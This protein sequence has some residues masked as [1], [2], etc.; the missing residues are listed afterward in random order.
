MHRLTLVAAGRV[1]RQEAPDP[2][3]TG[4]EAAL[5][6]PIAASV[7]DFDRALISGVL[8]VLPLPIALGHEIVA[9]VVEIGEAVGEVKVGER[10][11]LPLQ[12]SCGRCKPCR[13]GRSNS[14][15][16]VPRLSNYGL[17][18]A[19]GDY[20]GGMSDLL[21]VPYADAMLVAV[22][23]P[24]SPVDCVAVGCNLVDVYR[25]LAPP[26]A[27]FPGADVLV[28]GGHGASFALYTVAMARVLGAGSVDFAGEDLAQ[29]ARAEAL[30]ANPLKLAGRL[31]RG[32]YAVVCDLSL[33]PR[34]LALGAAACAPD[35]ICMVPWIYPDPGTPL[36][37]GAMFRNNVSLVTGQPHARGLIEPV[38][39]L[40]KADAIS[41]TT[42]PSE[43]LPWEQ[44]KDAFG[45][46]T[47]KRIFVR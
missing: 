30:G 15:E 43:V 47:A 41:S 9:E 17:G 14:C 40:L 4:P 1:E 12:V 32:G 33:D 46:G 31:R 35:G 13:A 23:E 19:G 2:V 24:L 42:V 37:L 26:L 22:P 5:V 39:E 28:V 21:V 27:A 38:L 34:H 25:C 44:A 7:C 11:I 10:V 45:R 3:L 29:L 36:P 8:D 20:G 18:A 16:A 6:R